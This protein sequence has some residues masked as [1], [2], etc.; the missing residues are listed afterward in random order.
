VERAPPAPALAPLPAA[1]A[2]NEACALVV[3]ER[4]LAPTLVRNLPKDAAAFGPILRTFFAHASVVAEMARVGILLDLALVF[5]GGAATGPAPKP[6]SVKGHAQA[7]LFSKPV[8]SSAG[9]LLSLMCSDAHQGPSML[10]NLSQ[11]MPEALSLA[12]KE[13][14]SG[15]SGGGVGLLSLLASSGGGGGAAGAGGGTGSQGDV[16]SAFDGDHETPELI[17][18]ATCRHELRAALGELCTGLAG[19]RKRAARAVRPAARTAAGGRCPPPSGC[20][21]PRA[22]A[23]CAAAACTC[24]CSSRSPLSRCATPRPSWRR[25]CAASRLRRT[26]SLA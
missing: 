21:F 20:A 15:S 1:F 4:H 10:M 13:S 23:S 18:N 3:A 2:P 17:W 22:R 9:A 11:L 6:G 26:T 16:V 8:R 7:P 25:C 24:A 5:V 19:L 14:V 12:I